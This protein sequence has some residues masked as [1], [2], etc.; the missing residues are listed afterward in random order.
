MPADDQPSPQA[1]QP[2]PVEFEVLKSRTTQAN[3]TMAPEMPDLPPVQGNINVTIQLVK[4]PGLAEPLPPLSSQDPAVMAESEESDSNHRAGELVFLSATVYDHSRTLLRILPNGKSDGELVVWS[5]LDFNHFSGF[6]SYRVHT[7]DGTFHDKGLLMGLG[8][9]DLQKSREE[10][11]PQEHESTVPEIATL[12][13]LLVAGPAYVVIEGETNGAAMT[14]LLQL[15]ELY[16]KEGVRM[17]AAFDAREQARA[18]R[19]AF[20]LSNP[21]QPEDVTIRFWKRNQPSETGV[22]ALEGGEAQP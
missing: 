1:G 15:Q 2:E 12:P 11:A 4:D 16:R 22:K 14:T 13:D 21:P 3:V 7:G 6:S 10:S 8:N 17:K 18:E 19:R 5:N 9:I 20:L